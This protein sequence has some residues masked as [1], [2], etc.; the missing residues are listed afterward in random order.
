MQTARPWGKRC[1]LRASTSILA[2]TERAWCTFYFNQVDVSCPSLSLY[3]SN[4]KRSHPI[5]TSTSHPLMFSLSLLCS[6]SHHCS[7]RWSSW[8]GS[9]PDLQQLSFYSLIDDTG[10]LLSPS[11]HMRTEIIKIKEP[12]HTACH[13]VGAQQTII[14]CPPR[15][16]NPL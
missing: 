15:G 5:L 11:I 7:S 4:H 12:D 1:G 14:L 16:S 2:T 3:I 9:G 13:I 10:E 6:L 8:N